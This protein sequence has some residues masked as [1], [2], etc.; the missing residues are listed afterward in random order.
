MAALRQ[1]PC[2]NLFFVLSQLLFLHPS[3]HQPELILPSIHTITALEFISYTSLSIYNSYDLL[4]M[5]K[6][7]QDTRSRVRYNSKTGSFL[8][9][10]LAARDILV[11]AS[12]HQLVTRVPLTCAPHADS[13]STAKIDCSPG[14]SSLDRLL[15][16]MVGR[17][18]PSYPAFTVGKQ[19]ISRR[20]SFRGA[21]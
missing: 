7:S 9:Q 4:L 19:R 21:S 1:G 3:Q 14:C 10:L 5:T 12:H 20:W 11:S 16:S 13:C 6:G 15:A 8:L 2:K 18:P 17:F